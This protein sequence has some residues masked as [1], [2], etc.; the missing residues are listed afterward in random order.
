MP[1]QA[2]ASDLPFYGIL[3]PQKASSFSKISEDVIANN[4]EF[5]PQLKILAMPMVVGN[6]ELHSKK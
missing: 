6:E 5:P 4:L 1:N 3:G 2:T